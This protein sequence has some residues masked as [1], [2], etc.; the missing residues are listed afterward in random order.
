M[1][2]PGASSPTP[3]GFGHSTAH[4]F[5]HFAKV[6]AAPLPSGTHGDGWRGACSA[7]NLPATESLADGAEGRY[8]TALIEAATWQALL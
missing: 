4:E 3:D 8:H 5:W 2:M 6:L 1:P 7:P